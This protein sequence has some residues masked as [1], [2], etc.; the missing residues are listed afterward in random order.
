MSDIQIKKENILNRILVLLL[1]AL[2][3]SGRVLPQATINQ[4]AKDGDR[5]LYLNFVVN[6]HDFTEPA[7]AC[8]TLMRAAHIFNSHGVKADFYFVEQL[9]TNIVQFYPWFPDSLKVLGMGVNLH[10]RAPHILSFKSS[11]IS[12]LAKKPLD[13]LVYVLDSYEKYRL[14][15]VTGGYNQAHSGGYKFVKEMFDEAPFT[16]STGESGPTSNMGRADIIAC[17]NMGARGLLLF[18]EDGS[19]ADYP[20]FYSQGMLLRPVDFSI[21]RWTAGSQTGDEFWWEKIGTPDE[22]YY[23]PARYLA[24]KMASIDNSKLNFANAIIH[25]TDF[26]YNLPPWRACYYSDSMSTVPYQAPFD[27][28][29]TAFWIRTNPGDHEE[30]LWAYYDSLVSYAASNPYIK[31]YIMKDLPAML[32]EDI[33][34]SVSAAQLHSLASKIVTANA[35][36]FPPRFFTTGSDHFSVAD[37]YY[38]LTRSLS[39]YF[40]RGSL[41]GVVTTADINGPFDTTVVNLSTTT[42]VDSVALKKGVLHCDSL[43]NHYAAT[44]PFYSRIPSVIGV[45]DFPSMNPLEYLYVV[46]SAYRNIYQTGTTGVV[47]PKSIS[48]T[49]KQIYTNPAKWTEKPARRVAVTGIE[50]ENPPLPAVFKV[51][52]NYPNPFNPATTFQLRLPPGEECSVAVYNAG[53]ELVRSEVVTPT[54]G[55]VKYTFDGAEAA[56]GVYFFRFSAGESVVFRKSIL[57]K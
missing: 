10:H 41:P 27:T 36:T 45:S 33:E 37:A 48:F 9:I 11:Y 29:R 54:A 43:F 51:S 12:N 22:Y 57:I 32:A 16:V 28:S 26:H 30:R 3:V 40:T 50:A 20:L 2:S 6:S 14:D 39:E 19:D 24:S 46:A 56:S 15:L 49:N 38:G 1:I 55:E 52:Q 17:K 31:T 23:A 42:P 35:G 53:G 21:T 4:R 47:T 25:E 13:T 44:N 18:H 5:Y 7:Q 8:K 34:R